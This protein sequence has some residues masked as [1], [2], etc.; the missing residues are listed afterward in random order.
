MGPYK[1][2]WPKDTSSR[3]NWQPT[4][5]ERSLLGEGWGTFSETSGEGECDE[6]LWKGEPKGN[7][8]GL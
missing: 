8:T 1:T 6:E 5:W 2:T 4:D 3:T 7:T